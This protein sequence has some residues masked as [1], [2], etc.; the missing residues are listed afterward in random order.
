MKLKSY[1]VQSMEEALQAAKRDLGDEAMLVRTKP[2]ETAP[3]NRLRLEV[4]FASTGPTP[5]PVLPEP[6]VAAPAGGAP[7]R[8]VTGI[9]AELRSLLDV[10]AQPPDPRRLSPRAGDQEELRGRLLLAGVPA[11]AAEK[12]L[13]GCPSGLTG[14]PL[15]ER[16]AGTWRQPDR[17]PNSE[18]RRILLAGPAGAGKSTMIAKLAF[19]YAVT[20]SQPVSVIS[21]DN[22]RIGA[23]DALGRLCSLIGVP[24]LSLD[25]SAALA[26]AV[27]AAAGRTT[28][29]IDTPGFGPRDNDLLDETAAHAAAVA[30]LEC[31]LVLPASMSYPGM[32][33]QHRR[34]A[35]FRPSQLLPTRLDES[36]SL[37]SL[38]AFG[39]ASGLAAEWVSVGPGVPEDIEDV[40]PYRIAETV[41]AAT[42]PISPIASAAGA[43]GTRI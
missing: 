14:V 28:V 5:P 3:G 19:R 6:A 13:A 38:W 26:A 9:R 31:H 12:F 22:L 35:P 18:P 16:L 27:H 40:D 25:D 23:S 32:E 10:L 1:F 2:L 17:S 37:G 43:G 21:V 29:L 7:A 20:R 34:Y 8:D 42:E 36:D 41:L 39:A 30:G 15:I 24:F 4:V 33:R 11:G